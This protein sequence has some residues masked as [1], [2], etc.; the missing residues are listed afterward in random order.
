MKQRVVLEAG[1]ADREYYRDIWR[2][3]ELFYIL[4]WRDISVRYRQTAIG[5][6][7]AAIRP[8]IATL[9]FSVV[10]GRLGKFPS[11][12]V[13]YPLLVLSG[14]LPWQLFSSAVTE[15]GRSLIANGNLVTKVYFPRLIIPG[16][17]LVSSLIDFSISL[18]ILVGF[19]AFYGFGL[20]WQVVLLPVFVLM[21]LLTAAGIGVWIAALAVRYRD[22]L[23]VVPFMLQLGLYASPVA[24]SSAVVPE[25]W[26]WLFA[27]NPMAGAIDGF[28]WCI[29]GGKVP[30]H[31][32]A[33]AGSLL[34][35]SLVL[36][37]GVRH[38][39][40]AERRFADVI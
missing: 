35:S 40:K 33:M 1:R 11:G 5:I 21:A 3:R 38:F 8:L 39:R 31:L 24:F 2:H 6:A 32:E 10:F 37:L 13:P 28:R 15:S 14:L 18:V 30:L 19:M 9:I 12:G 36:V 16:S 29:L 17:S 26:R 22:F 20:H 7:W 23:V 4:A 27:L 25:R 34:L